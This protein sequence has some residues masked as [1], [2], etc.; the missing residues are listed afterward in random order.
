MGRL[1]GPITLN[2]VPTNYAAR[3]LYERMGFRV[4]KEFSGTFN[5]HDVQVMTLRAER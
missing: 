4:A 5:G 1:T 3:A 2:V